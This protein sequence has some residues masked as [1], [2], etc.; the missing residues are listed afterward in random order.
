MY[1]TLSGFFYCTFIANFHFLAVISC[2]SS[3]KNFERQTTEWNRIN[4]VNKSQYVNS[5]A[6]F[7]SRSDFFSVCNEKYIQTYLSPLK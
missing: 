6:A 2:L 1:H 7:E 3:F 4:N 5:I